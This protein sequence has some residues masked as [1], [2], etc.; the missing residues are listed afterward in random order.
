MYLADLNRTGTADLVFAFPDRLEVYLNQSGNGFGPPLTV[1]L[2]FQL[3]SHDQVSFADVLG[4]GTTA[5]VITR[6][7]PVVEHWYCGLCETA[8]ANGRPSAVKRP[9]LLA[10][11]DN[12]LGAASTAAYASSTRFLLADKRA[13]RPW[14][15]RLPGP[16][17]VLIQ[18]VARDLVGGSEIT[19]SYHYHDGHYDAFFRRFGGFG[20]VERTQSQ[21]APGSPP[22]TRIRSWYH[23]GGYAE[24]VAL[25]ARRRAQYFRGDPAAYPMPDS[26]MTPA[27]RAADGETARQAYRALAGQVLRTEV[28]SGED[29]PGAVPY[30]V[31]EVNYTVRLVQAAGPGAPGSF[32]VTP[33][34][35]VTYDYER[36]PADPRVEHTI[37]LATTLVDADEAGT[38]TERAATVTYPRR[39]SGAASRDRVPEQQDLRVRADCERYTRVTTG[40]RMIGMPVE[41]RRLDIG[42]LTVP[43]AAI[44]RSTS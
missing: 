15:G 25:L 33:R 9:N 19:T 26:V 1:P 14:P 32:Y 30:T 5:I 20:L 17:Q 10:G 37:L 40:F 34:E 38:Y 21:S 4:S 16:V 41:S 18:T 12:N 3:T 29:G 39:P 28:Y 36:K 6:M 24:S 43:S 35:T 2:P 22:P 44:S 7:A 13:G 42:G 8:A 31:T 23:T 11:A 27:V